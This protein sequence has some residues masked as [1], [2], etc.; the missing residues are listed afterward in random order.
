MVDTFDRK[1][2]FYKLI[3][4]NNGQLV[5]PQ[6][7][8]SH[9]DSLPFDENGRYLALSDGNVRSMYIDSPTPPFR[10]RIGTKRIKGLPMV[11]KKGTTSPLVIPSD[12]G[13]FE[14]MHCMIFS[15]NIAGFESNFYGP[16]PNSMK[17]YILSKAMN[18]VDDIELIPLMRR[19]IHTLLSRVGEI[20]TFRLKVNRDM[21][22]L[23]RDLDDNLPDALSALKKTTDA[24]YIEIILRGENYSRTGIL[25]SFID[26]LANW[27]SRS[28]VKDGVDKLTIRAR[29]E[30]SGEIAEFD[31]LQQYILSIKQVIKQDDAHRSVN[32]IAMYN[33][34]NEAF[35]E[36]RQEINQI[37]NE[38][39]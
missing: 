21:E 30:I 26:R 28:D 38:G 27:I 10:I 18:L 19:D 4:K 34:I 17:L 2:Y 5:D 14:P 11:E 12:S 15:N 35:R 8:F 6:S 39:E 1:I 16:R 7:V 20:R 36:M 31:V 32:S 25:V 22:Q 9:I 33:A 3:F 23:I 37:I 29:D 24:E 13:L